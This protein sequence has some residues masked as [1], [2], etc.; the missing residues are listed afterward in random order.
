MQVVGEA[1]A[2]AR[3][4]VWAEASLAVEALEPAVRVVPVAGARAAQVVELAGARPLV[5]ICG[6]RQGRVAAAVAVEDCQV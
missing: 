6:V 3:A 5:E 4:L 1:V 2:P